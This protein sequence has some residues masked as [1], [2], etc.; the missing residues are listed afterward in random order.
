MSNHLS[1]DQL[2]VCI[3][4]CAG[5]SELAHLRDCAE[6]RAEFEHFRRSLSLFRSAMAD[7]A[8]GH[9]AL[10]QSDLYKSL[11]LSGG[12]PKWRWA[13]AVVAFVAAVLIPIV[14]AHTN[15]P[16]PPE[17]MS[18]E[19]VMERLNEHLARRV[20]APMEPMMSLIST[21]PFTDEPG[22]VQQE[23]AR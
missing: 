3:L 2:E 15:Q 16:K 9:A 13:L 7:I 18:P 10:H 4:G 11:L 21:E 1:E 20:P 19:A 23:G 8:D 12:I 14:V 17:P 22:A 6:C 5:Q